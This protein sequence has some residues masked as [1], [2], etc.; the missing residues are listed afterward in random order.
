VQ[1]A[2]FRLNLDIAVARPG[3]TRKWRPSGRVRED[4][5]IVPVDSARCRV[6]YN[7]DFELPTGVRGQLLWLLLRRGF[8][9]GPADSLS[10]LKREAERLGI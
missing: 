7:C 8:D 9:N 5:T 4:M 3:A 2:T 1:K 6:N 10:R